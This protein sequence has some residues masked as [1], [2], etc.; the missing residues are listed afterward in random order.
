[1]LS[2]LG[3]AV[4]AQPPWAEC[5]RNGR[6][7][8]ESAVPKTPVADST[9]ALQLQQF[10]DDYTFRITH[11]SLG[12][13]WSKRKALIVA[14][15]LFRMNGVCLTE[16]DIDWMSQNDDLM[17]PL[18]VR[19]M[20]YSIRENFE[21]L[22]T[23]LNMLV[24]TAERMRTSL[25]AKDEQKFE[26][27]MEEQDTGAIKEQ[28]LKEAVIQ[29]S[30]EVSDLLR[31]QDTW[32]KSMEKRLDRLSR[33]AELAERAQQ[34]LLRVE[35]Q[36]DCFHEEVTAK[37]KRAL[38]G[39]AEMGTRNLL[40]STFANWAGVATKFK[41]ERLYRKQFEQEIIDKETMLIKMKEK[42]MQSVKN[43]LM[44]KSRDNDESLMYTFFHSWKD[45]VGSEVREAEEQKQLKELEAEMA[46]FTDRQAINA[47]KVM[48]RVGADN[49]EAVACMAFAAW[50]KGIEELRADREIEAE[51]KRMD[52]QLQA[53]KD[54]SREKTA[55]VIKRM[56]AATNTSV[57]TNAVTGWAQLTRE[58]KKARDLENTMLG[59]EGKFKMLS[60]RH[61][62]NATK[63]QTRVNEQMKQVLMQR[64]L[65][66]W[67]LE[68]KLH[69][70]EKYYSSKIEGKRKQLGSV[71]TLFKSFAKQL[72]EGLA[73]V[74]EDGE[75]SSRV[76][77]SRKKDGNSRGMAK[78]QGSVSLPSIHSR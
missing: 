39:F 59:A 50:S 47:K 60:N 30:V 56:G 31:C 1:V 77:N 54:Q 76:H 73:T 40:H 2:G 27:I 17:M 11:C 29:A 63:M 3:L 16:E 23:Q 20:P 8:E 6:Q 66:A 34:Q 53:Y 26:E 61:K 5:H 75:E 9:L 13:V 64:T 19:K 74:E 15:E 18:I 25:E 71:Q 65:G 68:A 22:S 57:L 21:R 41:N 44:R 12:K 36:L 24:H 4:A 32:V 35:G 7:H 62:G 14:L 48:A 28:I 42:S 67:Q 70:V 37:S 52:A 72:E 46:K 55:Q 10:F 69:H 49:D 45:D 33:S 38:M 78:G 51:A 43:A 58:N